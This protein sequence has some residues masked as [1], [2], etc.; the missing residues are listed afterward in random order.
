M[1]SGPHGN[2]DFLMDVLKNVCERDGDKAGQRTQEQNEHRDGMEHGLITPFSDFK[3][4][5]S[6]TSFVEYFCAKFPKKSTFFG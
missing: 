1:S 4:L 3:I 6:I 2:H 5:S